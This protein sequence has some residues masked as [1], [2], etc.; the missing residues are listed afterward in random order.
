L[1]RRPVF[2]G[3]EK[4]LTAGMLED[5]QTEF[6]AGNCLTPALVDTDP[7]VTPH[8][9]ADFPTPIGERLVPMGRSFGG[10]VI[11]S[12]RHAA[13]SFAC[14]VAR[15]SGARCQP[16]EALEESM[17]PPDDITAAVLVIAAGAPEPIR[18]YC[19][20]I[21]KSDKS[22]HVISSLRNL[23][24][25]ARHGRSGATQ[26]APTPDR[27]PKAARKQPS[28]HRLTHRSNTRTPDYLLAVA[29]LSQRASARDISPGRKWRNPMKTMILAALA[30]IS[31]GVGAANAQSLSHGA[32]QMQNGNNYNF[33]AD[34]GG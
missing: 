19:L 9:R 24:G 20:F 21:I 10:L 16:V 2:N 4:D 13:P 33:M 6:A 30:A 32:P 29:G 14:S 7:P 12:V 25:A 5:F 8:R 34:S 11:D 28:I 31:L 18:C 23:S 27:S 22:P 3:S 26:L 17:A 1:S 15:Q